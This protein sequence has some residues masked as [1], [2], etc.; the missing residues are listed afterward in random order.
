MSEKAELK[1]L[2]EP[3]IQNPM[4]LPLKYTTTTTNYHQSIHLIHS[5]LYLFC[6]ENWRLKILFLRA[7]SF[8][9]IKCCRSL[10][11]IEIWVNK[12]TH[13][14]NFSV[15]QA[16]TEIM[17]LILREIRQME[18]LV[19]SHSSLQP[20]LTQE[21][22]STHPG[23]WKSLLFFFLLGHF[24]EATKRSP[25]PGL[26]PRAL[27]SGFSWEHNL[28][29]KI[30]DYGVYSFDFWPL[31]LLETMPTA[32]N[33]LSVGGE[34]AKHLKQFM[35]VCFIVEVAISYG[36][37]I[38]ADNI[39]SH[40]WFLYYLARYHLLLCLS[41]R[42]PSP[43]ASSLKSSTLALFW[44]LLPTGWRIHR[45][46][47][48]IHSEPCSLSRTYSRYLDLWIPCQKPCFQEW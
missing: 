26:P 30:F 41:K 27:V 21:Q 34:Q 20:W 8:L 43:G 37:Q 22:G 5:T 31:N 14:F 40:F 3:R 38:C 42:G 1:T 47:G 28:S 16:K 2:S 23:P 13:N 12:E 36:I 33:K 9:L 35:P 19:W 25:K 11:E 32:Q 18:G 45:L 48:C 46:G 29:S 6:L 10:N 7:D 39:N 4:L 17:T 44:S 15:C 24:G